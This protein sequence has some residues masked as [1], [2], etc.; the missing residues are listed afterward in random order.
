M[1]S[2]EPANNLL[3][4]S[5]VELE[6]R[7]NLHACS[8]SGDGVRENKA[9]TFEFDHVYPTMPV[10]QGEFCVGEFFQSDQ[11]FQTLVDC[12]TFLTSGASELQLR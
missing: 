12:S 11:L 2:R 8:L 10:K 9:P 1:S 4:L 6:T 7:E 3:A 5:P